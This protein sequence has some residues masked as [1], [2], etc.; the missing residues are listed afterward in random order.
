MS[1]KSH[2]L[3]TQAVTFM[4]EYEIG[5]GWAGR[6]KGLWGEQVWVIDNEV[7]LCLSVK[8]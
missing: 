7:H 1:A 4:C 5:N 3:V 6:D 2:T 8:V